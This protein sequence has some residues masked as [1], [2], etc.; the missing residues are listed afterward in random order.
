MKLLVQLDSTE[1]PVYKHADDSGLDLRSTVDID[2][3][4]GARA[5]V[6]TG[7]KIKLPPLTEAQVR[8]RSGLAVTSG[9]TVLNTPGTV[10]EGYRGEIG[11]I[12][13]N[14]NSEPFKI[15]KG[16]RIAQLVICP[17]YRPEIVVVESLDETKRGE[18]GFG[19][20]GV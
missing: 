10:D 8:P 6:P 11:V 1:P 4:P 2:L 13:I 5:L 15:C 3:A 12:M 7:I 17:I 19:S 16:D 18:N 20:T 14:H 9:V